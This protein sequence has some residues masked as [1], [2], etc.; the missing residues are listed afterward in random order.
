M[1][2]MGDFIAFEAAISLLR[3]TDRDN[4]ITEV[5]EACKRQLTLP[6]EECV[7]EV[8]RIYDSFTDEEISNQ[9]AELLTPKDLKSEVKIIFQK[10]DNLHKACPGHTGD[11]YFT[12]DYP[13]PGG[14]RVVNQAF[15]NWVENKNVRAY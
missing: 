14:N 10:V 13:T 1:A 11:W 6:K 4:I 15:V 9:I 5:Y 12:G 3:T 7:N 8:R 2:K